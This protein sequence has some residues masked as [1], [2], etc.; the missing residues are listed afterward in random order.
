VKKTGSVAE[1]NTGGSER[2]NT[3]KKKIKLNLQG[4]IHKNEMRGCGGTKVRNNRGIRKSKRRKDGL[5]PLL[6][7]M[8][9]I[10]HSSMTMAHNLPT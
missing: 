3:T 1:R 7:K 2:I 6:I 9:E 10:G 5:A 8:M 4:G